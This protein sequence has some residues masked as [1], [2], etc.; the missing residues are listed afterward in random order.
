[1]WDEPR[2]TP[3]REHP[4]HNGLDVPEAFLGASIQGKRRHMKLADATEPQRGLLQ[5]ISFL[6]FA[7][8]SI[9]AV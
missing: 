3:H 7:Q 6:S 2:A 8:F 5:A 4:P 1:M 9:V